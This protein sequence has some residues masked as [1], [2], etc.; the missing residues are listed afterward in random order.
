MLDQS[1]TQSVF[2]ACRCGHCCPPVA[3]PPTT[4][5]PQL[6]LPLL[7]QALRIKNPKQK[8]KPSE[9]LSWVIENT[10]FFQKHCFI[11]QKYYVWQENNTLAFIRPKIKDSCVQVSEVK[12]IRVGRSKNIFILDFFFITNVQ[13]L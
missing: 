2:M 9:T 4:H 11:L 3:Q 13:R 12:K 5:T 8:K 10:I 6:I 1:V 7:W